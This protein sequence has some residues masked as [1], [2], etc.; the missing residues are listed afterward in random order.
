MKRNKF[1]LSNYKLLTCNMGE[2]IPV[3]WTEVIPG[4]VFQQKTQALIRTTPLLAPVM[5]PV[6]VRIHH[7]YVPLRLL[8]DNSG[9]AET[10]FEAFITGGSDGTKVPTHPY[11]DLN[12]ATVAQGDLLDYL[13]IP[14][15]NYTGSG[16]QISA[17]PV[18]AY[19]LI[20]NNYYRDQDLVTERTIDLTDGA[21]A[22]STQTVARVAWEKDGLTTS[23]P[24]ES[25]GDSIAIPLAA[26]AAVTGIGAVNQNYTASGATVYETDGTGSV[27]YNPHKGSID[28]TSAD[29]Q[30]YVEED[31]NNSGFPNIRADLTSATG[32]DVNDLLL[33]FGLQNFQE[34]R[35]KYGSRYVEYLRYLG[36]KPSDARLQLPEYL[37]G[38]RQVIQFSEVLAT[39]DANTGDMKGHGITA[40]QTNRY[41]RFFEEHGIIMTLMSVVPKAIYSNCIPKKWSRTT[42]E[43]YFTKELQFI[44]D[45]VIQNK[46]VYSE[47][48]SPSGTFSY[49]PRYEDYRWERSS[50]AGEFN[51]GEVNDHYHLARNHSGDP[52]LNSTFVSCTPSTNIFKSSAVDQLLVMANNSIQARRPIS[53]EGRSKLLF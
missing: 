25:K 50:I 24:W 7:F 17:L 19:N 27:T 36:I 15:A 51:I 22:T 35:A 40:L 4:D 31:P 9:G 43:Q 21:D 38:G 26:D 39:D 45:E 6:R 48:S 1:S 3:N 34:A 18:R 44:G 11:I 16:I 10:G 8:W 33:A 20:F 12:A 47:H 29:T 49:G 5:H 14:P 13:G 28:N 41:R 42:K 53:K 37:G 52:S 2:L 32:V 30:F 46:E 23:R